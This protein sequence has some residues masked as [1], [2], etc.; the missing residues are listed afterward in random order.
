M[1]HA[2]LALNCGSSSLKYTLFDSAERR[3]TSGLIEATGPAAIATSLAEIA[4]SG[5]ALSAI[6]HRVVHGGNRFTSPVLITPVIRQHIE[7]LMPLATE[8]QPHQVAGIDAMAKAFPGLPQVACFDTVFHRTIARERQEMALPGSFAA[9]G[10]LRYGFHGLSFHYIATQFPR[11][12]V[13][14]CHLGNGC[15]VAAIENGRSVYTSM[16]FTPIDGLMMGTRSGTLDPG[17]VLWLVDE[18]GDS[19]AVRT[20]IN[21]EAGLKGVSGISADMRQ[22]LASRDPDAVFAIAMFVDRLVLEVGRAAAALQGVDTL[23][24]TGGIGENATA[25]RDSA[26]A[27]L[28]WLNATSHVI[29]TDE[30]L[31]IAKSV[32]AVLADHGK[33]SSPAE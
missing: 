24:F 33:R 7:D 8:H 31:M 9:R 12:K 14:A 10:L 21:K 1:T 6:G 11:G 17:A 5:L 13:I 25:I 27:K 19:A 16:G 18:L 3:I 23:V 26:L 20:L 2:I 22:L 32:R 15:S 28:A 30:E 29:K 4:A